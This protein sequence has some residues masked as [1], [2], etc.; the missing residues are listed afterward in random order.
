MPRRNSSADRPPTGRIEVRW[1]T[2]GQWRMLSPTI[3]EHSPSRFPFHALLRPE[4]Q[5]LANFALEAAL[6]RIVELLAAECFREV[7]LP[8]K[9]VRRVVVVLVARAVV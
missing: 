9:R 4:F 2:P 8:G 5:P 6:G 7:V 3:Q 1:P